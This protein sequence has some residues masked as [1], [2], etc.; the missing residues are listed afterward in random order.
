MSQREKVIL[1]QRKEIDVEW[2]CVSVVLVLLMSLSQ[3]S[4]AGG[5]GQVPSTRMTNKYE[6][7]VET[8]GT[9]SIG[10]DERGEE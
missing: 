3:P 6:G 5:E 4:G 1:M 9:K 10:V 7:R 2:K 8:E